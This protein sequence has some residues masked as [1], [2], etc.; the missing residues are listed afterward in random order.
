MFLK[1]SLDIVYQFSLKWI[2]ASGEGR[3]KR[4]EQKCRFIRFREDEIFVLCFN[5]QVSSKLLGVI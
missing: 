4:R 2:F 3:G 5:K 1:Y